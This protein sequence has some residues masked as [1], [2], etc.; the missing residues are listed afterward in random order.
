MT[1]QPLLKRQKFT[2]FNP[3]FDGEKN[4]FACCIEAA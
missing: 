4:D 3:F 2:Q 1:W